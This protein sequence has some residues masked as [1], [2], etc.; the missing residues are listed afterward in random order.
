MDVL[1]FLCYI[2]KSFF[3]LRTREVSLFKMSKIFLTRLLTS[4]SSPSSVKSTES[5]ESRAAILQFLLGLER[6]ESWV[7]GTVASHPQGYCLGTVL[8]W[9]DLL[10][11]RLTFA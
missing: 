1:E 2:I 6:L 7:K 11:T 10:W 8:W 5:S 4:A 9:G 3:S